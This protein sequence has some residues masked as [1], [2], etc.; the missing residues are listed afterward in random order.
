MEVNSEKILPVIATKA[1]IPLIPPKQKGFDV[2]SIDLN[3]NTSDEV[4][5]YVKSPREI[6]GSQG[7]HS[8]E[9]G[10]YFNNHLRFTF[11]FIFTPHFIVK[12]ISFQVIF[13]LMIMFVG[14]ARAL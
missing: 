10:G 2:F 11:I 6:H 7:P 9:V 12:T 8:V 14:N 1:V 4:W 5:M 13:I 3:A